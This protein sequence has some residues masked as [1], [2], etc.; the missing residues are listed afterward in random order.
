[1]LD[2]K[3]MAG[4]LGAEIHGLDLS[5]QLGAGQLARR[6]GLPYRSAGGITGSK[7]PDAQAAYE[8]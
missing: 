7:V 4:A 2:I 1:M 8:S 6:L 5:G 3:P